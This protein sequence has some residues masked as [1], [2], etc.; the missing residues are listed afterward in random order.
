MTDCTC[1]DGHADQPVVIG[2][3][4]AYPKVQ[5]IVVCLTPVRTRQRFTFR[6]DVWKCGPQSLSNALELS[7]NRRDS[8]VPLFH[9]RN[10]GC[11]VAVCARVAQGKERPS[12]G[13]HRLDVLLKPWP[14]LVENSA[15]RW[16]LWKR[17]NVVPGYMVCVCVCVCVCVSM[18]MRVCRVS[19]RV[20]RRDV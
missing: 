7:L 5:V 18:C 15:G 3:P 19:G 6:V 10:R 20:W 8:C 9:A 16:Q 2:A 13:L 12:F 14:E 4:V 1:S 17:W 11:L